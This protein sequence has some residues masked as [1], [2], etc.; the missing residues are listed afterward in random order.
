MNPTSQIERLLR[1][2]SS[3][4]VVRPRDLETLG[5]S[6]VTLQRAVDRGH[7]VRRSRGVYVT[8]DQ[9]TT[10][11]ADVASVSVRVPKAV[12]C[13][14]SAL[15]FHGLTTQMPHAVWI[16]IQKSAHRP[17]ITAPGIRVVLASGQALTAGVERHR[18][19]GVEV[20]LTTPA[21]T[22]ADCFR[23]RAT[24]GKDVAIEALRDCLRKKKATPAEIFEMAKVDRVANIIRPTL[25]A[26]A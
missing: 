5:V 25:E 4:G 21:K 10:R 1:H 18:I 16:M 13:L 22:V 14:L 2:L 19:E 3:H 23:Y 17:N 20:P 6:R 12:V 26:L 9:P 8:A 7:V 15:D 11:H 24:V